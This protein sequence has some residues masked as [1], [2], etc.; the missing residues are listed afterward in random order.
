MGEPTQITLD[1]QWHRQLGDEL[2]K[3]YMR[4]LHQFLAT[5]QQQGAVIYPLQSQWFAAL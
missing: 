4:S 2:K 1:P 3:D 5:R